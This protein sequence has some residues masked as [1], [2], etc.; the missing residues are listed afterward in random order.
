V[1]SDLLNS[2]VRNGASKPR[3]SLTSQGGAGSNWD[4]L[5]GAAFISLSTSSVVTATHSSNVDWIGL[6]DTSYNGVAAVD[7]QTASTLSSKKEAKSSADKALDST[8]HD[9][10]SKPR[11][12]FQ[13]FLSSPLHASISSRQKLSHLCLYSEWSVFSSAAQLRLWSSVRLIQ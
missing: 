13:S 4:V 10:P 3:L 7:V 1:L 6:H 9:S 8:L 11:S 2:N 5:F 12:V